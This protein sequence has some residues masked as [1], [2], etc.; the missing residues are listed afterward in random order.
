MNPRTSQLGQFSFFIVL[1]AGALL[2]SAGSLV[3]ETDTNEPG[4][5]EP[6]TSALQGKEIRMP[7][8]D[9]SVDGEVQSAIHGTIDFEDAFGP[10][11]LSSLGQEITRVASPNDDMRLG[12]QDLL[13]R[14]QARD[15]AGMEAAANELMSI[16][17]GTTQ[18]RI[19]DGFPMLNF[20]RYKEP[21]IGPESY[22]ADLEPGEYKLKKVRDTGET[23]ENPY[24]P[25]DIRKIWE[26]DVAMLYYDGQIDS[27]TFLVHFP[28]DA[29]PDDTVRVNYRVYTLV[30]EDF[31]PTVVMLDRRE[32]LNTVQFPYK[33]MDAV[34]IAMFPG[35]VMN[36]SIDYST[37]RQWRG[38]YTWGW[39]DHPPRIQFLQP[40][41]DIYDGREGNEGEVVLDPQSLS[42]VQR[43]REDLTLDTIGEAAPEKKMYRVAEAVLAGT[44]AATIEAWLTQKNQGPL[45]MWFEWADLAK[46]QTQLPPEVW[47]LLA[48]EG[49]APGDFGDYNM[50]TA[51]INNEAYGEGPFSNEVID[52]DQGDTFRVKLV[53]LDD[54]THYFRNV[55]F[56]S[57]LHDDILRCCGG[58]E[59]SFEIM[60]FKPSYGAP[61]VAEMQWRAGWGFRPHYDVIQQPDVFPRGK[62]RIKLAP[63]IGGEG[64]AFFGYQY[65]EEARGGDFRFNPPNF[66]IGFDF[67]NPSSFPLRDSDGENGLVIGRFTEGYGIGQMCPDDPFPG[68]CTAD[69][70][71]YNPNGS[72]NFPPPPLRGQ[73]VFPEDV[74]KFPGDIYPDEAVELRYPPFLRN[75]SQGIAGAGDIIP[76]TASWRP[77]LW[78]NPNNGTLFIDPDDESKGHWADLTYSHGAPVFA[79]QT[80]DATIELP[81]ASG[82]VFYQFDDLFHDNVIFSP[83]PVGAGIEDPDESDVVEKLQARRR[84]DDLHLRGTLSKLTIGTFAEWVTVFAGGQG[85]A[86]C[87][88]SLLGSARVNPSGRFVFRLQDA[89]LASGTTVCVQSPITAFKDVMVE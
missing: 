78:I 28:A 54:H 49:L 48:L 45:G 81:R 86:G 19:Y 1:A 21:S 27:D 84:G 24:V 23:F 85:E 5:L 35:Q 26:V 42:F 63:Y 37:I 60:N 38:V 17:L 75:P 7:N 66:I 65:S 39:R 52:W 88:G 71:A 32:A 83:H 2:L 29:H 34:W 13:E 57:R 51:L 3:A 58:G 18:G 79:G 41:Y 22:Q 61:K 47:D 72:K 10:G 73:P 64:G 77:F 87:T 16:L 20:N 70:Q 15:Q 11:V 76:P 80:L 50:I 62:D 56:G 40:V 43:N 69:I 9:Q 68:F 55:D 25:G 89:G 6:V 14:A 82:Q 46:V 4:I 33:G 31:S 30:Q 74:G 67:D 53:N 59:T 36:V 12:L 8:T 44:D